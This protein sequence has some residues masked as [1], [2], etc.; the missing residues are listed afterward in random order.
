MVEQVGRYVIKGQL[1]RGAMGV[2]Y[3]ADDPLLN[4]QAAIKTV[5]L[6]AD[7]PA[8]REFL[9]GRLLR[10]ARAAA[11][12][13]HANIVGVFD[14]VEEGDS[15]YLVMEYVAGE[16]LA[17][18]LAR[19]TM[20]DPE[21]VIRILRDMAAALDYT[22]ARGIVHRDIKPANVMIDA[23]Q[24]AKIMDFGIARIADTRTTTP[25]GMVMGTIEYMSPEQVKG[26]AVD[27]RSDQ[28]AMAAVA[29][30]MLTGTTLF[31]QHS[32][33]T[34]AYKIV[35][36]APPAP[37]M[38]NAALPGAV[39]SVISK[40]LS[41]SPADRYATCGEFVNALAG[42]LAQPNR[43]ETTLAM[44]PPVVPV[45]ATPVPMRTLAAPAPPPPVKKGRGALMAVAAI[46]LL[47]GAGLALWRPWNKPAEPVAPPPAE[48]ETTAVATP[49]GSTAPKA[50]TATHAEV[51]PAPSPGS[52]SKSSPSTGSPSTAATGTPSAQPKGTT[53]AAGGV[54]QN[55]VPAGTAKNG[56]PPP[57]PVVDETPPGVDDSIGESAPP[58]QTPRPAVE[59]FQQGQ[60]AYNSQ[61]FPAAIE[62][63]NKA[64]SLRPEWPNPIFERGRTYLRMGD[65]AA[66]IREFDHV[67]RLRPKNASAHANRGLAYMRLKDDNRA[68][69][70]FNSA[71]A[72]KPDAAVALYGR[73]TI[74]MRRNNYPG[75]I[76]DFNDAI[77][78]S[79]NYG[80]AFRERGN[81]KLKLGDRAGAEADFRRARELHSQ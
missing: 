39:D 14:V 34:L 79:P 26:E 17:Q 46:V 69:E 18:A 3:L 11:G 30:R 12:L 7:D 45:P 4:R 72:L 5:D 51:P 80:V 53:E 77:R 58:A 67:L 54:A 36:E 55:D 76:N 70:D 59:A 40:A 29:Y 44:A 61:Q 33:A 20:P 41:K 52:P 42:A 16:T 2:V 65:A 1:G 6:A 63:Y 31:G 78:A 8:Q 43:E 64:S 28:F 24:T 15:A 32:L 10:D 49:S 19:V 23:S 47:A 68:M 73:G 9:R 27:G 21:F 37:R 57:Q 62:A 71:I 35:N 13:T 50:A 25:T 56:Q 66:A 75:A 22:H 81:A 48:P 74:K 38:H 60:R